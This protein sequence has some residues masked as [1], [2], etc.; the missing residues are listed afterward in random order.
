MRQR[1][2]LLIEPQRPQTASQQRVEPEDIHQLSCGSELECKNTIS[3]LRKGLGEKQ[4]Y[5][6]FLESRR[7]NADAH[8]ERTLA[9]TA[10]F[11]DDNAPIVCNVKVCFGEDGFFPGFI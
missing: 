7:T 5:T 11:S 9:R 3:A 1:N 6:L 2:R 8:L 10:G 4:N